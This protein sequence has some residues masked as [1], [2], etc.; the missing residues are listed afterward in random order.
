MPRFWALSLLT[1]LLLSLPLTRG[2]KA[3]S[4]THPP[5]PNCNLP[6]YHTGKTDMES[7]SSY[8]LLLMGGGTDVDDAF[9]WMIQRSGGGDLVVL[10]SEGADGY[11]DYLYRELGGLNSVTTLVI[12]SREQ[13]FCPEVLKQVKQAEALFFAGGDQS[14]YYR[15]WKDTPLHSAIET[16]ATVKKIPMGGTS[17][18]LAILGEILYSAEGASMQ[19]KQVLENP[20]HPELTLRNDFLRLPWMQNILTDSHFSERQRQGRLLA[21]L[22]RARSDRG[23]PT[24]LKGIGIDERTA[25]LVEKPE[26]GIYQ[27]RLVGKVIGAGSV[28]FYRP[29]AAPPEICQPHTPLTWHLGGNAVEVYKMPDQP[30]V[31]PDPTA[32]YVRLADMFDLEAWKPLQGQFQ[33]LAFSAVAGKL[34]QKP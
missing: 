34:K 14:E 26:T 2:A 19:S 12:Q 7:P 29:Q 17:A 31:P 6:V 1:W 20:F 30:F 33:R 11:N 32:A 9:R 8:G 15:F 27:G 21:F 4:Q 23:F 22:A 10:R 24:A 16:L 28:W 13:A 25:L 5:S 18:G 3:V